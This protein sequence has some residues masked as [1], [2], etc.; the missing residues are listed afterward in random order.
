MPKPR[1][2]NII[3]CDIEVIESD[4][5]SNMQQLTWLNLSNNLIDLID[6]NAFSNLKNLQ[7]I[8]L[9]YNKLTNFDPIFVGLIE[10]AEYRIEN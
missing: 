9:S 4:S 10:L 7:T 1:Q 3:D 5:F 8:D 6:K 2:L